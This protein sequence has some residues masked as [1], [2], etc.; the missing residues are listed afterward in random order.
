MT[1]AFAEYNRGVVKSE[2][3]A[4]ALAGVKKESAPLRS[5]FC[6]V[7]VFG[8]A[9]GDSLASREL[10]GRAKLFLDPQKLIVFRN[11]VGSRR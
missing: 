9:R 4:N 8:S 2:M 3:R 6:K 11:A 5:A 1:F 7:V 10:C